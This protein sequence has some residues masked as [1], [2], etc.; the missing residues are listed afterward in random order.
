MLIDASLLRRAK[1]ENIERL[2]RSLGVDVPRR[3]RDSVY[4]NQLVGAIASRIRR[5]AMMDELRKLTSLGSSLVGTQSRTTRASSRTRY[6][7]VST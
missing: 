4:A 6:R 5:D 7:T 2:A 3:K 1:L